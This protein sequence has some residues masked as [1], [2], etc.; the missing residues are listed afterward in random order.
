MAKKY[1]SLKDLQASL[2]KGK[3]KP[4]LPDPFPG[5]ERIAPVT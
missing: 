5:S 2:A 3:I 1:F 4:R